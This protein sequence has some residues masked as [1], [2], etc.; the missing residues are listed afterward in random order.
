MIRRYVHATVD[1]PKAAFA[2]VGLMFVLGAT[3]SVDV[4]IDNDFRKMVIQRGG[5]IEFLDAHNE[6]FG[7]DDTTLTY[8]LTPRPEDEAQF[9]G[10]MSDLGQ[11]LLERDEVLR[12]ESP[13]TTAVPLSLDG[14]LYIGPVLGSQAPPELSRTDGITALSESLSGAF[15]LS[16]D[17]TTYIVSIVLD[18]TLK[19]VVDIQKP[20]GEIDALVQSTLADKKLEV[21]I[22]RMG[23]AFTRLAA[24]EGIR[25]DL[26]T[27]LPIAYL[28]VGLLLWRLYPRLY[29]VILPPSALGIACIMTVGFAAR[30]GEPI[31]PL[32]VAFPILVLVIGLGDALH[33]LNRFHDLRRAGSTAK[34]AAKE[35]GA[36]VGR[37]CLLTT[38]TSSIGFA[39]LMLTDMPI[40]VGFGLVS[41]VGIWMAFLVSMTLL[42]AALGTVTTEPP[43]P[44]RK[45]S[46]YA[47]SLAGLCKE[48][49]H[50]LT[51]VV[52]AALGCIGLGY[53]S[54]SITIDYHFSKILNPDHPVAQGN[55]LWDESFPGLLSIDV[56]LQ[57]APGTFRDPKVLQQLEAFR[58]EAHE[59]L[60]FSH[61][62]GLSVLLRDINKAL[63][64]DQQLPTSNAG[65]A[66]LLLFAESRR[67]ILETLVNFDY[68]QARI[69][70]S[71]ASAGGS[72]TLDLA[73]QLES[74]C[75]ALLGDAPQ[76]KVRA[77]GINVISS[78]GFAALVGSLVESLF[79]ALILIVSTM[80]LVFRSLRVGLASIVPNTLPLVAV[81][82]IFSI[83]ETP[84]E[85]MP[86][87]M[88]C[89][90][91]GIAVDDTIHFLARFLDERSRGSAVDASVQASLEGSLGPV[92]DTSLII[93]TGFAVLVFSSFPAN[94]TSA[95]LGISI[96]VVAL[97]SDLFIMPAT[98]R[99]G[100]S[101]PKD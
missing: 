9:F 66:Q 13:V 76:I 42:P 64:N 69:T 32:S 24:V 95:L 26:G 36:T 22:E 49:R 39:S 17:G 51:L 98:M 57:G 79:G 2:L 25:R 41:S 8:A 31:T 67:D 47:H 19:S 48:R 35:A 56:N 75:R 27:L 28:F 33:M 82:G 14:G 81:T 20:A 16:E 88:F 90:A 43:P 61:S 74:R 38:L 65:V 96:M 71:K 93:I 15:L 23:I 100:W 91:I 50:A 7:P 87:V 37:A 86:A 21:G 73:S 11:R 77:T 83:L 5:G 45:T 89:I 18:E 40:L 4:V 63:T 29:A 54:R 52:V 99:I 6:V 53:A 84:L 34:A 1:A 12:I 85:L 101:D 92:V 46:S 10:W 68:S 55:R 60:S 78:E 44:P 62:F 94:Q 97:L 58:S 72:T 80:A 59:T 70:F 3:F 30:I